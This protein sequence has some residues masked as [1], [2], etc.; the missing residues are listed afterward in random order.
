MLLSKPLVFKNKIDKVIVERH[1]D[2]MTLEG[3]E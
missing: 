1:P 3:L 2:L